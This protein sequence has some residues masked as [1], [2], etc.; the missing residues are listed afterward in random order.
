VIDRAVET[1]LVSGR[2]YRIKI[3]ANN[4]I[5]YSEFSDIVEI[6]MVNPPS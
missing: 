1:N 4:E 2:T 3:R 5:G 6:A